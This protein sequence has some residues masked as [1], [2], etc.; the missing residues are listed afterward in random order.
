MAFTRGRFESFLPHTDGT[1]YMINPMVVAGTV[2]YTKVAAGDYCAALS[3]SDTATLVFKLPGI[4]RPGEPHLEENVPYEE[5][6][7]QLGPP[8]TISG[9]NPFP[10]SSSYNPVN[11]VPVLKGINLQSVD[12]IYLVS[13]AALSSNSVGIYAKQDA[14]NSAPSITTLV[15]A[16]ANGLQTAVQTNR[17]LTRVSIPGQ[18]GGVTPSTSGFIVTPDTVVTVEWDLATAAGGTAQVF[19]VC[20]NYQFNYD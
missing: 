1:E 12:L 13:G 3:A 9:P 20:F 17:Y 19:G 7:Q 6:N 2:T 8:Y 15:T 10:T 11:P 4:L 16:G 14:N 5:Y 18:S